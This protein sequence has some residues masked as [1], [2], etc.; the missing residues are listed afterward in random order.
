MTIDGEGPPAS[1]FFS[2]ALC[3]TRMD[4]VGDVTF[5]LRR[6]LTT[7]A[8]QCDLL[9]DGDHGALTPEAEGAVEAIDDLTKEIS[10]L[11]ARLETAPLADQPIRPLDIAAD[12]SPSED[13]LVP[14][15]PIALTLPDGP[16][17]QR[18]VEELETDDRA[19]TLNEAGSEGSSGGDEEPIL[20]TSIEWALAADDHGSAAFVSLVGPTDASEPIL[21]ASGVLSPTADVATVRQVL[22][23]FDDPDEHTKPIAVVDPDAI[24]PPARV[25]GA[26]EALGRPPQRLGLDETPPAGV[27][28]V[29][30]PVEHLSDDRLARLRAHQDGRRAPVVIVGTPPDR[31]DWQPTAGGRTFVQRPPTAAD[32]AGELLL[33]VEAP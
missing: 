15:S 28:C 22:D 3:I 8:A 13:A 30:L 33:A 12:R 20:V 4:D 31:S 24:Q 6:R 17:V 19:V 2:L 32:L 21:G 16:F 25:L 29:L 10:T 26:L 14:A 7:V 23:A 11:V 18:L 27:G 1:T 5:E 9:R